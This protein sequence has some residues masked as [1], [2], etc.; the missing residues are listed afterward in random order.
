MTACEAANVKVE[1]KDTEAGFLVVFYRPKNQASAVGGDSDAVDEPEDKTQNASV[2]DIL[3][4]NGHAE[5]FAIKEPEREGSASN[6]PESCEPAND[7]SESNEPASDSSDSDEPANDDPESCDLVIDVSA[8]ED[9]VSETIGKYVPT[10]REREILELIKQDPKITI[11]II[12]Q[13][14]SKSRRT[15][16]RDFHNLSAENFIIRI[17]TDRSGYWEIVG[18]C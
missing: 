12:A 1:F 13:I 7:G 6:V 10:P 11:G 8:S 9:A 17:G 2:N 14:T 18:E 16:V 4:S 3:D 5:S 15:I